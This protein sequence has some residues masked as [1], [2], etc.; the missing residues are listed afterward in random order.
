MRVVAVSADIAYGHVVPG[1]ASVGDELFAVD[2][3][4]A[5][6][7]RAVIE[8]GGY[9]GCFSRRGAEIDGLSV[10]VAAE[11]DLCFVFGDG[12]IVDRLDFAR[13]D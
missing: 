1:L 7:R 4:V 2:R 5:S 8:H 12:R 3:A 11:G 10:V 6:A 9:L 13:F